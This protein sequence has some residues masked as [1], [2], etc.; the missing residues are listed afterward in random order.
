MVSTMVHPEIA[1]YLDSD[2]IGLFAGAPPLPGENAPVEL[3]FDKGDA[4][5]DDVNYPGP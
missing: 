3:L 4:T 1:H 2:K 5:D